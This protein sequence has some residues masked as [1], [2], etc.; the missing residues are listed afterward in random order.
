MHCF[1]MKYDICVVGGAG[2][3][4]LPLSIAFANQGQR[5]LIYDLNK[6]AMS[7][8][9]EGEMPFMERGAEPLLKSVLE[10]KLLS[11][12][13]DPKDLADAKNLII[14][15]GTP[16]DEFL[17]PTLRLMTECFKTLS[18]H[19]NDEQLIILRSTVYPGVTEWL[20][21][22]LAEHGLKCKV[23]FCPE[24][25]VQGYAIEELR[26][27]PQL[28]SGTTKEAEDEAA[29]L[30]G[31]I[32]PEIVRI[33]TK[34]AEF[35]K[36]FSNAYR[37]ITFGVSNQ[38]YMICES[39]GVDYYRVLDAMKH[40]YPRMKDVSKAGFAAGPCLFKDT[41]QLT[42]FYQNQFTIGSSAMFVNEGMP[43]FIVGNLMQKHDLSKM[44]VGLLGMAFK[45]ESDDRRSSLSYKL[46]KVLGAQA[47][48]VLT[49]DPFVLDDKEIRPL[50]EV[51]AES[52]VLILCAPHQTYKGL[53]LKNK[54]VVDIWNFWG[55][56]AGAA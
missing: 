28:V 47:R 53:S 40:N 18:P 12:S 5:V 29:R 14:T 10:K 32:A 41:M 35:A 23:S 7:R 48:R 45:S 3:V 26:T 25:I 19:M 17:N 34:E 51:I 24:R 9:Q 27:L 13:S 21:K 37:Y 8:I 15:I 33:T 16:V 50:N 22:H 55:T 1:P 20:S 46:K 54:I 6:T 42:A 49:T 31:L 2:H 39:A 36:L 44:T 4:G 11:F 56:P 38:F 52:D 30:F 43:L